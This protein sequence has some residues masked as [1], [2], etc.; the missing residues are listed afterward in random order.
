MPRTTASLTGPTG[1]SISLDA[2]QNAEFTAAGI[3][4]LSGRLN[5][6]APSLG[7][8]YQDVGRLV[9]DVTASFP[10]ETLFLSAKAVSFDAFDEDKLGAAICTAVG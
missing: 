9:F 8:L 3:N 4:T 10:G 2:H 5:V 7:L 1:K 6:R